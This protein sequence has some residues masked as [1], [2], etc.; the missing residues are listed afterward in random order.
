MDELK[1]SIVILNWNR[2]DISRETLQECYTQDYTDFEIIVVDNNSSDGSQE[3]VEKEF[4]D[5]KLI[6]LPRNIG[7]EGYNIGIANSKGKIIVILDN[8]AFLETQGIKKIVEKFERFPKLGA[9]GVKV[10]NYYTKEIHNWHPYIRDV[11][12]YPEEGF[13]SPLFNGCA[14]ALRYDVLK[15]IGYYPEEFFLYENERDLCTRIIDAGF[16]VKYF[17]D[18]VA[19]HK[20]AS[21]QR[22]KE[23]YLYFVMRNEIWY[24]WK[25]FPYR[26]VILRTIRALI[27]FFIKAIRYRLLKVYFKAVFDA[28]CGL[29]VIIRK[30]RP[31]KDENIKKVIY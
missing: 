10:C 31:V 21:E 6:R 27:Y 7:I 13:D 18:I 12:T 9:L 5:V 1:V 25:Y 17:P 3:M 23:N 15:K 29:P 28:I 19:Y 4:P 24:F 14:A 30:R 11:E 26:I 2:K 20:V 22:L 8:D 16:E